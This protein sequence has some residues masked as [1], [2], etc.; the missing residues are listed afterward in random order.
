[1][2]LF[3]IIFPSR[4]ELQSANLKITYCFNENCKTI[5]VEEKRIK[6]LNKKKEKLQ[7]KSKQI[8]KWN[9]KMKIYACKRYGFILFFKLMIKNRW[10]WQGHQAAATLY[11]FIGFRVEPVAAQFDNWNLDPTSR[12]HSRTD[13]LSRVYLFVYNNLYIRGRGT[14]NS[15]VTALPPQYLN[16]Y[17][18]TRCYNLTTSMTKLYNASFFSRLVSYLF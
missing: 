2:V 15:Y 5:K 17:T 12:N 11:R 4:I 6:K 10:Q 13:T 8:C 1:M 3:L 16:S 14:R 7:I 18:C 9:K